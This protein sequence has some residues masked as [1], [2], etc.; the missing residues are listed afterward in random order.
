MEEDTD[1]LWCWTLA[2]TPN[3]HNWQK[4]CQACPS[5][6][7]T[8]WWPS[9]WALGP[10]FTKGSFSLCFGNQALWSLDVRFIQ[11]S[12]FQ[13]DSQQIY[14]ESQFVPEIW[15]NIDQDSLKI[16]MI[17]PDTRESMT[18]IRPIFRR[19]AI[20]KKS[21]WKPARCQ[22]MLLG[23]CIWKGSSKNHPSDLFRPHTFC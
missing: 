14:T 10:L 5:S 2:W 6:G 18:V 8:L 20:M 9:A 21:L 3:P 23:L 13:L 7:R 11:T 4:L 16:S 17:Y 22:V 15:L 12:L 19:S 1:V